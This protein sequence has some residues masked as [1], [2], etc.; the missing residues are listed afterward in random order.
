LIVG[1]TDH[2]PASLDR[3]LLL[4]GVELPAP[5]L[6]LELG[7]L[8]RERLQ[9]PAVGVLCLELVNGRGGR[10]NPGRVDRL[11]ERVDDGAIQPQSADCLASNLGPTRAQTS[12]PMS[13]STTTVRF[14][15]GLIGREVDQAARGREGE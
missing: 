7:A 1:R 14:W 10:V 15:L 9:A 11:K 12:W 4:A 3:I 13:R 8:E 5:S 2:Q 6:R